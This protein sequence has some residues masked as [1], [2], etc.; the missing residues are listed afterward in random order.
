LKPVNQRDIFGTQ[1]FRQFIHLLSNK[2]IGGFGIV[3]FVS[4]VDLVTELGDITLGVGL[5]LGLVAL[6]G[7]A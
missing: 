1:L 6:A 7:P 3:L 5:G 2:F 4:L